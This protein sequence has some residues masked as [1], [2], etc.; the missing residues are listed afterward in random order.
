MRSSVFLRDTS[1]CTAAYSVAP[2]YAVV[3]TRI[4]RVR[5]NSRRES[6]IRFRPDILMNET[7]TSI[8]SAVGIWAFSSSAST[9]LSYPVMAMLLSALTVLPPGTRVVEAH[10]TQSGWVL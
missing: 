8:E 9:T 2:M 5:E 4:G 6:S 7:T 1:S 3:I 10:D